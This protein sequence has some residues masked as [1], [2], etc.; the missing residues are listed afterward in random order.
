MII[1]EV[2]L[3]KESGD[4]STTPGIQ[5]EF[6]RVLAKDFWDLAGKVRAYLDW[7][8]KGQNVR[9]TSVDEEGKVDVE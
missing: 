3:T 9:V 6:K 1:Y 4:D 7:E 5:L 8:Y 2:E